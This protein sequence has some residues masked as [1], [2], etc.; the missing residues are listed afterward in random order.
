MPQ[1]A[2]K[3]LCYLALIAAVIAVL[4]Y[5]RN[6]AATHTSDGTLLDPWKHRGENVCVRGIAQNAKNNALIMTTGNIIHIPEVERWSDEI[7]GRQIEVTGRLEQAQSTQGARDSE[8]HRVSAPGAGTWWTLCDVTWR[9][10]D[11]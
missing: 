7:V 6:Y 4:V 3:Y 5:C 9:L 1:H 2:L 10:V 8:G 11:K